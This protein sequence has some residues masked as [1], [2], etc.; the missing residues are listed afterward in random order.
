MNRLLLRVDIRRRHGA[1]SGKGAQRGGTKCR[2]SER[3]KR[4]REQPAPRLEHCGGC[5]GRDCNLPEAH[6]PSNSSPSRRRGTS[7]RGRDPEAWAI[8]A[9]LRRRLAERPVRVLEGLQERAQRG[10][11]GRGAVPKERRIVEKV[12]A[13]KSSSSKPSK[14][15]TLAREALAPAERRSDRRI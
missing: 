7:N 12:K 10:M 14:L 15:S 13:A 3:A 5:G 4:T 2:K 9:L 11:R 6:T 8:L 1:S